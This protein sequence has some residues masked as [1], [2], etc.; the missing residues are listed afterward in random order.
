MKVVVIRDIKAD[1]WFNPLVVTSVGGAVRSF[2]DECV[3][4]RENNP[5]ADHP[6]DYELYELGD[7]NEQQGSFTLHEK[8]KQIAVG[9]NYRKA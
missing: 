5:L 4:K 3:N 8:P 1:L 2:G 7:W 6:E 9:S